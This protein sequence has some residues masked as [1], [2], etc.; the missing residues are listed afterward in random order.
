MDN[1]L[2]ES[3]IIEPPTAI[4]LR[5]GEESTTLSSR[6]KTSEEAQRNSEEDTSEDKK[7]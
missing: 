1:F 4:H 5:V 3:N 6:C 2:S 7:M